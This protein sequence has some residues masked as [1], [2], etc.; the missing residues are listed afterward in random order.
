[1][2]DQ[3][4]VIV[5]VGE[6]AFGRATGRTSLQLHYDA[7]ASALADCG[8]G[9]G[10]VD[11][12]FSC[13]G[14]P[15]LHANQLAEYLGVQPTVVDSTFVGGSGWLTFVEHACLAIRA[16]RCSV[17]LL[18]YGA[19]T[20]TEQ[21]SGLGRTFREQP[22]GPIQYVAP[23]GLTTV[24]AYALAAQRHM[25]VH[26]TTPEHLAAIAVSARRNALRN[27]LATL[28][29]PITVD[30]VLASPMIADPLH[31]LD[32]CLV[33]DGGGAV[34]LV[35]KERAADLDTKPVAVLGAG[36]AIHHDSIVQMHDLAVHRAAEVATSIAM[37]EAGIGLSDID[38]FELYDSF[39]ITALLTLEAIGLCGPGEGGP[40]AA[41]GALAWDGS[42]PMN[43]D[44]G[45]LASNHPGMRGVFLLIEAVRQLRGDD[46]PWKLP[47]PPE[48]ALCVGTSGQL[49]ASGAVVLGKVT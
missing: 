26:A 15:G 1:M 2:R 25:A 36:T 47:Q 28:R 14:T 30:D 35:S 43:T 49:S 21:G 38:V 20:R 39:T 9:F 10:D 37:Q 33:T 11:G 42:H 31:V 45:G 40:F 13:S 22:S 19:A 48:L 18:V 24:G 34:V 29:D 44:G 41:T 3:D 27:P 17:A 46:I 7:A 12:L 8:L 4:V 6:S 23:M 5:G 16:G 32:C